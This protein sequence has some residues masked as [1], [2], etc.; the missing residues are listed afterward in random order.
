MASLRAYLDNVLIACPRL[1]E[2]DEDSTGT[3]T[4]RTANNENPV[5]SVE[6]YRKRTS[7]KRAWR[8]S[9]NGHIEKGTKIDDLVDLID[10]LP[11]T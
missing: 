2:V 10:S 6:I 1:K 7:G 5:F 8:L 9:H 4:L 3:I 11:T